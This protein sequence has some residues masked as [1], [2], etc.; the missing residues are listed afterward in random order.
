[1]QQTTKPASAPAWLTTYG[2]FALSVLA[3]L[4]IGVAWL[5]REVDQTTALAVIGI[6]LG[7]NGLVTATQWQAAP[8]LVSDLQQIISQ[9]MAHIQ[10]LHAQQQQQQTSQL[11]TTRMPAIQVPAAPSVQQASTPAPSFHSSPTVSNIGAPSQ[12]W[13]SPIQPP[14]RSGSGG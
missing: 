14:S 2:P 3:L 6:I 1:M 4:I 8:G 12:S 13:P 5:M 11:S 7:G 10:T 9:L